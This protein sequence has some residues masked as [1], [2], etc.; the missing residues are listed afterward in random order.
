MSNMKGGLFHGGR[1]GEKR[2]REKH[3]T[4]ITDAKIGRVYRTMLWSLATGQQRQIS[5]NEK[6]RDLRVCDAEPHLPPTATPPPP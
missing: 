3:P 1:R 5:A 4:K 6:L 2:G